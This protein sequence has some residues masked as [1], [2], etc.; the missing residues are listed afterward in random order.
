MDKR[1]VVII[2]RVIVIVYEV[3]LPSEV[4]NKI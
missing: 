1:D 2:K 4:L 3:S